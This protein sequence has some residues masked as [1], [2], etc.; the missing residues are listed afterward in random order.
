MAITQ[1]MKNVVRDI[2]I[3]T[4]SDFGTF[5]ELESFAKELLSS[6]DTGNK[7]LALR[8]QNRLNENPNYQTF[9]NRQKIEEAQIA[10]QKEKEIDKTQHLRQQNAT[11][12]VENRK[13]TENNEKIKE[14]ERKI[15]DNINYKSIE[16]VKYFIEHELKNMSPEGA[17]VFFGELAD[18]LNNKMDVKDAIKFAGETIIPNTETLNNKS[19]EIVKGYS[20]DLKNGDF[21]S[22]NE[23]LKAQRDLMSASNLAT[24]SEKVGHDFVKFFSEN[25]DRLAAMET[26]E[27][28]VKGEIDGIDPE[29]AKEWFYDAGGGKIYVKDN[30]PPEIKQQY[31]EIFMKEKSKRQIEVI[32]EHKEIMIQKG[33]E[34]NI[35]IK[36]ITKNS[37]T[38]KAEKYAEIFS[39]S[40]SKQFSLNN[41]K[42]ISDM[43]YKIS[44]LSNNF[45]IVTSSFDELSKNDPNFNK[46][47][48]YHKTEIYQMLL[49]KDD[50]IDS[51][52]KDNFIRELYETENHYALKA[53][54]KSFPNNEFGNDKSIDLIIQKLG[55]QYQRI[56][57]IEEK[58]KAFLNGQDINKVDA[59][60]IDDLE[61]RRYI[62]LEQSINDNHI[63]DLK[64]DLHLSLTQSLANT[65][66][67]YFDNQNDIEKYIQNNK[68]NSSFFNEQEL[69][70]LQEVSRAD[71]YVILRDLVI[72]KIKQDPEWKDKHKH[73]INEWS[74][75]EYLIQHDKNFANSEYGQNGI[76]YQKNKNL[77]DQEKEHKESINNQQV[78]NPTVRAQGQTDGV[79]YEAQVLIE[80]NYRVMPNDSQVFIPNGN[81][82]L[83]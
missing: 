48:N 42:E 22:F 47:I 60:N 8:I 54:L 49:S 20:D 67:Q 4:I 6:N 65:Y 12:N 15:L 17:K 64:T 71:F 28:A 52:A 72:E 59:K 58:T 51:V 38:E 70:Q 32:D 69:R 77:Q 63:K 45:E 78:Y 76:Q 5:Q 19:L 21:D 34:P 3:E 61:I 14:N 62:E 81:S 83:L 55:E 43:L 39:N 18:N 30:A 35:L 44:N 36:D 13:R 53:F 66:N 31:H 56:D 16:S 25:A 37:F 24:A 2:K 23:K 79:A 33:V 26:Y 9:I 75:A 73:D 1:E 74:I 40:D 50:N 11:A 27:R 57:R 7:L 10:E 80:K 29:V 46:L 82:G 68:N 41:S